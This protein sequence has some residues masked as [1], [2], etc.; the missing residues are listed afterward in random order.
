MAASRTLIFRFL[1][2]WHPLDLP[3]TFTIAYSWPAC[4]SIT[5]A[6]A[7]D[8][9]K[10][11]RLSLEVATKWEAMGDG[12]HLLGLDSGEQMLINTHSH[13]MWFC[14]LPFFR[15]GFHLHERGVVEMPRFIGEARASNAQ[16]D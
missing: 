16:R 4:N 3:G 1:Q 11:L 9:S 6:S 7:R 12:N 8:R 15:D 10:E 13:K 5:L 2:L 14:L